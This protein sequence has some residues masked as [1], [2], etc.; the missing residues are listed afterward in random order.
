MDWERGQDSIGLPLCEDFAAV[1]IDF[2]GDD[3]A[4]PKQEST[5]YSA[6]ASC[7]QMAFI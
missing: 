3:R 6:A 7:K 1:G 4:M 5:K 2:D